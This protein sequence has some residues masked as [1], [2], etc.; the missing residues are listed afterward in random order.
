MPRM[1]RR[2]DRTDRYGDSV[3]LSWENK[4]SENG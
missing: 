2:P 3:D 1:N 4:P